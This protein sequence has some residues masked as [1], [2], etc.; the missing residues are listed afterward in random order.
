MGIL[1]AGYIKRNRVQFLCLVKNLIFRRKDK[2]C[3]P[4]YEIPD[5]PGTGYPVNFWVFSCYPF[6]KRV[7][8]PYLLGIILPVY[9]SAACGGLLAN[10]VF[11]MTRFFRID[12]FQRTPLLCNRE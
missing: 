8:V 2:F 7:I 12:L 1:G 4:I 3:V 11:G 5:E 10:V 9:K 6:H